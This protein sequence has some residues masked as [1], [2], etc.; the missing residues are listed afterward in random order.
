MVCGHVLWHTVP[1]KSCAQCH[2]FVPASRVQFE[3]S[4][5]A[6]DLEPGQ[7]PASVAYKYRLF[8]LGNVKLVAR[9]E[10]H[11]WANKRGM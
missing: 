2:L 7:E 10:L 6:E 5:F 4:P 8:N 9:C 1:R 11:C 3:P